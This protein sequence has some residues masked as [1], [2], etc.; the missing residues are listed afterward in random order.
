[1]SNSNEA[2]RRGQLHEVIAIEGELEGAFKKSLQELD[3]S[4]RK[5]E[6]FIGFEKRYV[7][8]SEAEVI[9]ESTT[10]RKA[11]DATVQQK[12]DDLFKITSQYFDCFAQREATNQAANESVIIDGQVI[13]SGIPSTA[14]LGLESKLRQIKEILIRIP[15]LP[16]GIDFKKEPSIG[17]NVYKRV[18]DE[19]TFRTRKEPKSVI[20]VQPT[21]E[22]PAQIEK[23]N[24]NVNVGKYITSH[25]TGVMSTADK[26]RLIERLDKLARAVKQARQRANCQEVVDIHIGEQIKNWLFQ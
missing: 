11:M 17:A 23:W 26:D 20:L 5:P 1:M 14:L 22:H 25:W 7:P 8:F 9:S 24:E 18:H 3:N 12:L 2:T 16:Q 10:E 21:K 19:E 6:Q 4:F 13:L 15:V